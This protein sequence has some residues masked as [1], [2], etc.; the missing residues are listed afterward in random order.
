MAP[1]FGELCCCY[2]IPLLPAFTC[3]IHATWGPPLSHAL[4]KFLDVIGLTDDTNKWAR[5]INRS[6][7]RRRLGAATQVRSNN[8]TLSHAAALYR[9]EAARRRWQ[10]HREQEIECLICCLMA[11]LLSV[12]LISHDPSFPFG[13]MMPF[14]AIAHAYLLGQTDFG[15][16]TL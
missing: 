2:C 11:S 6:F 1:R 9:K 3:S 10:L 14:I 15:R 16:G 13:V 12:C 4:Y 5:F 8:F 7:E